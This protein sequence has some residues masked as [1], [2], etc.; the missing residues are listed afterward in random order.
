MSSCRW[1]TVVSIVCGL[2]ASG[3]FA[4]WPVHSESPQNVN[5]PGSYALLPEVAVPPEKGYPKG[6]DLETPSTEGNN[7]PTAWAGARLTLIV[8]ESSHPSA[9]APGSQV[10]IVLLQD[11]IYFSYFLKEGRHQEFLLNLT[12]YMIQN[13]A[14][15]LLVSTFPDQEA[16]TQNLR[17]T[18]RAPQALEGRFRLIHNPLHLGVTHLA[19]TYYYQ[20]P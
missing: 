20:A 5:Q 13:R 14:E 12:Q 6:L 8:D 15:V 3:A 4:D 16:H 9:F 7:L 18:P 11:H 17:L 2:A 1:F 19:G 10:Q